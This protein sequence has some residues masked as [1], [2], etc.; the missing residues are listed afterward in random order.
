[1]PI[2]DI[3]LQNSDGSAAATVSKNLRCFGVQFLDFSSFLCSSDSFSL[4][5]SSH[6]VAGEGNLLAVTY[7]Y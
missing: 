1:M 2:P 5:I 4:L 3:Y 7:S 6:S